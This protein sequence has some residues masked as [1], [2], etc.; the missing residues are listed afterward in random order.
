MRKRVSYFVLSFAPLWSACSSEPPAD[1]AQEGA[2]FGG[3]VTQ[4]AG[5]GGSDTGGVGGAPAS[6]GTTTTGGALPSSGG[7][8]S[9]GGGAATAGASGSGGTNASSGSGGASASGSGDGGTAGAAGTNSTGGGPV[10]PPGCKVSSPVSFKA[11]IGPWL[12]TSCGKGK[13]GGCHVTDDASTI[14]SA[15]PDGT[16]KCG[17]NHAYDWITAG[18]HNEFCKQTP[19][20]IRFT[21]VMDVVRGANPASCTSTRVMPP[22][23]P[24]LDACQMAALEAWLAQPKVLQLHRADD[25]SPSEPYLMPPFN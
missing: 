24:P 5:A 23:S 16:K 6:A 8:P 18:A 1:S 22:D 14:N 17:F 25:T 21:V 3:Q 13:G 2:G 7:S 15:C 4:V 10:I 12:N 11:D 19:G 9:L 20:P